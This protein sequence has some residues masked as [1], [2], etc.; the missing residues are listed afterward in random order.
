MLCLNQQS[1]LHSKKGSTFSSRLRKESCKSRQLIPPTLTELREFEFLILSNLLD[2]IGNFSNFNNWLDHICVSN[3]TVELL[4][5]L[6]FIA[7]SIS[8]TFQV[9]TNQLKTRSQMSQHVASGRMCE[10][11]G[12]MKKLT[13]WCFLPEKIS[14]QKFAEP[15]ACFWV[16]DGRSTVHTPASCAVIKL[17]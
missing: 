8:F 12:G 15:D 16:Q 14:F 2:Y 11:G 1:F 6:P 10:W 7:A 13:R 9:F 3:L 17:F 5:I 4:P